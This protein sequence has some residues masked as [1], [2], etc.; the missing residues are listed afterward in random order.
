MFR[1]ASAQGITPEQVDGAF[2]E[3]L[4]EHFRLASLKESFKVAHQNACRTWNRVRQRVPGRPGQALIVPRYMQ[5]LC[6]PKGQFPETLWAEFEAFCKMMATQDYFD[7]RAPEKPLRPI[8]V[9]SYRLRFHM[10]ISALVLAGYKPEEIIN[11]AFC[12]A[13]DQVKAGLGAMLDWR[14]KPGYEARHSAASCAI[15]LQTILRRAITKPRKAD[16]EFLNM[17]ARKLR[18]RHKGMSPRNRKKVIALKQE[19]NL[20][21]LFIMP[22]TIAKKLSALGDEEITDSDAL[23]FEKG[24][25]WRADTQSPG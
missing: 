12:V 1:C 15:L 6:L 9:K 24:H 22:L 17:T 20:A 11:L 2:G 5:R 19:A 18:V 25:E 14:K 4:L 8:S 21:R 3:V 23:L 10:Y 7:R 16:V 13:K